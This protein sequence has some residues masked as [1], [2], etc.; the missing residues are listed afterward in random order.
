MHGQVLTTSMLRSKRGISAPLRLVSISAWGD[1]RCMLPSARAL[2]IVIVQPIGQGLGITNVNC[3]ADRRRSGMRTDPQSSRRKSAQSFKG[4]HSLGYYS[5]SHGLLPPGRR[6]RYW[7]VSY[8]TGMPNHEGYATCNASLIARAE[9][10]RPGRFT[11]TPRSYLGYSI[12]PVSPV[13]VYRT[14]RRT[15][16]AA[17]RTLKVRLARKPS[18]A[19]GL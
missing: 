6:W 2:R 17:S 19:S 13:P 8:P 5:R 10:M 14:T 11:P 16:F 15:S 7:R 18:A 3:G 1:Y 9:A 4:K 12:G